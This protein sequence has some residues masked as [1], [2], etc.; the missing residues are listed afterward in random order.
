LQTKGNRQD[1]FDSQCCCNKLPHA[2]GFQKTYSS[3]FQS[4]NVCNQ[5][6]AKFSLKTLGKN[7]FFV[8]S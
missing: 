1:A 6:R 3:Q 7:P 5:C 8:S 4:L 2:G